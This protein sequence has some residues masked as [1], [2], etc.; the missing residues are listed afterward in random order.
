LI[1]LISTG[2]TISSSIKDLDNGLIPRYNARE[3]INSVLNKFDIR[4]EI[5]PRTLF[6]LLSEEIKP[7]HWTILA[8]EIAKEIEYGADGIV[9]THGTDT[10]GYTSAALSFA[11][12]N[13][14]IP[15]VVVGSM[16]PFD[17]PDSDAL[18]NLSSAF[19]VAMKST[20]SGVMVV[21]HEDY[22]KIAIYR[23]TRIRKLHT[24]RIDAFKSI[25]EE[26]IGEII[27]NEILIK[28]KSGLMKRDKNR[29][30][31]LKPNFNDKATLIKYYPGMKSGIIKWYIDHG[32]RG[33]IIEGVGK[34]HVSDEWIDNMKHAIDKEVFIGM[35]SQCIWG[36]VDMNTYRSGKKLL[37]IGVT[38]LYD[39]I[40]ETALVKL[41]WVLAQTSR[42]DEVRK[43]ML[44]N[45]AGEIRE[46]IIY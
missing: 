41:M 36:S 35:T 1:S 43:L 33:I 37:K 22:N 23:G 30:I 19:I 44:T 24:D 39:M 42:I 4:V 15:I 16:K 32:Y 46:N 11:L 40:S 38:P 21:L 10:I 5:K 26:I 31:S 28:N 17:S 12:Q 20:F 27:N 29:K 9:I 14:P 25:N 34:G 8:N 2:G 18:T 7:I 6:N 13:L 45:L 3:L